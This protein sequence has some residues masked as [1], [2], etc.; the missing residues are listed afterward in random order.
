MKRLTAYGSV[1]DGV[2][3]IR[4]RKSFEEDMSKCE[5]EFLMT[6]EFGPRASVRF[7]NYYFGLCSFLAKETG[8]PATEIH[9]LN[10]RHCNTH[11]IA[12]PNKVTGELVEERTGGST[13][14]MA[15]DDLAEFLERVRQFWA[16]LGYYVPDEYWRPE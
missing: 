4:N 3:R 15:I 2:P 5:G 8:L 1:K 16:E 11:I 12:I 7:R 13:K 10:K 9:D 14:G 6:V